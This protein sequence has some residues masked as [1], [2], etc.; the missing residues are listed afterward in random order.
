MPS[1][2]DDVAIVRRLLRDAFNDLLKVKDRVTA[3]ES[4][5]NGTSASKIK[6]HISLSSSNLFDGGVGVG[7]HVPL[8]DKTHARI[9][10][11]TS[12][13]GGNLD[14]TKVVFQKS[15]HD[16][17]LKHTWSP[18]G[19][20]GDDI[21]PTLNP[22]AEQGLSQFVSKGCTTH[23][24]C[25]GPAVGIDIGK[26]NGTRFATGILLGTSAQEGLATMLSGLVLAPTIDFTFGFVNACPL[27]SDAPN[28]RNAAIGAYRLEDNV[29]ASGW[30]S[31]RSK[32]AD[33]I[34][35]CGFALSRYDRG[36]DS[37][38]RIGFQSSQHRE[39]GWRHEVEVSLTEPSIH[40]TDMHTGLT[41]ALDKGQWSPSF[42]MRTIVKF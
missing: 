36:D 9:E 39:G 21:V 2:Q 18:F 31:T 25:R 38:R 20:T 11:R 15:Q 4:G 19:A 37:C 40:G 41:L 8:T 14:V 6:G 33:A 32:P 3:L 27:W 1:I 22:N 16:G 42:G 28:F 34:E 24:G 7:L 26:K 13:F 10:A 29:F 30:I 35:S 17:R 5:K 23:Q 12:T